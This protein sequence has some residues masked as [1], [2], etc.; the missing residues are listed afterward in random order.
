MSIIQGYAPTNDGDVENKNIFYEQ[1]Q[2]ELE[3]IPRHDVI[4]VM[5]DMNASGED[6]G[7]SWMRNNKQQR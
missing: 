6:H 2:A 1:L 4:I 3:E 5:G 7:M